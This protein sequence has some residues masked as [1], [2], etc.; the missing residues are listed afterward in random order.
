MQILPD[1]LAVQSEVRWRN[2]QSQPLR[3]CSGQLASRAQDK[4]T[5]FFQLISK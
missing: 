3:R 5:P 2:R 4:A 1:C